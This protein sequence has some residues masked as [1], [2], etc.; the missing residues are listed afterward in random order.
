LLLLACSANAETFEGKVIRIV[1]GD[2]LIVESK[3]KPIRVRLKEIDAPELSSLSENARSNLSPRCA[4]T[5]QP[6]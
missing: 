4:Q 3:Q 1:D 6:A 2:S 5:T